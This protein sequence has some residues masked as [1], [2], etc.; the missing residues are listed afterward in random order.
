MRPI[1]HDAPVH[2]T[3]PMRFALAAVTQCSKVGAYRPEA[4][5]SHDEFK[6]FYGEGGTVEQTVLPAEAS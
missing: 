3:V 4:L 5:R 6:K 2:E 1:V